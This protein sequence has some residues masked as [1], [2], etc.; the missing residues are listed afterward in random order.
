MK[1]I[2]FLGLTGALL[3]GVASSCSKKNGASAPPGPTP[4]VTAPTPPPPS[5]GGQLAGF[6]LNDWQARNFSAP[7]YTDTTKPSGTVTSNVY[8]YPATVISKVSKY[9]FGNNSNPYMTQMVTE[10][11]LLKSI[12]DLAPHI[13][14]C[15]GV[16]PSADVYFWVRGDAAG[17]SARQHV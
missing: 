12:S 4:T 3:M 13:I 6:F 17:R 7:V 9:L 16:V 2:Q 1:T 5:A 8:V 10:P 11:G 15:P 14:R